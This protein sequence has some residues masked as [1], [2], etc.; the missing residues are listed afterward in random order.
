MKHKIKIVIPS[1]P[2]AKARPQKGKYGFYT[3]KTTAN[4]ENLVKTIAI[5]HFQN[6]ID[7][8]IYLLIKFKIPRPKRLIWKKKPMPEQPCDTRPDLSNL[9]KSIEDGLNGIAYKDDRQIYKL[10][11]EKVYHAG[12]DKSETIVWIVW[13]D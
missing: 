9:I 4:Y 7:K 2:I 5:Q 1:K 6:P 10:Y 8:P 11:A 12:N 13:E 3:P